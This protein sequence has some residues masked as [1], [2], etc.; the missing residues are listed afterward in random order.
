[1]AKRLG[2]EPAYRN[3]AKMR[4][5][6]RALDIAGR[7]GKSVAHASRECGLA[8][9]RIK[10][11]FRLHRTTPRPEVQQMLD[12]LAKGKAAR[13]AAIAEADAKE[14]RGTLLSKADMEAIVMENT[15]ANDRKGRIAT[16]KDVVRICDAL[17]DSYEVGHGIAYAAKAL[18]IPSDALR[19]WIDSDTDDTRCVAM[20]D[21]IEDGK[22]LRIEALSA[23]VTTSAVGGGK[24]IK[25]RKGQRFEDGRFEETEITI[26]APN[27]PHALATLRAIAPDQYQGDVRRVEV[28]GGIFHTHATDRLEGE[29]PLALTDER[30]ADADVIDAEFELLDGDYDDVPKGGD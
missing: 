15:T 30:G 6:I 29:S 24:R 1:M 26:S 25:K 16:G 13:A 3:K 18:N 27:G 28:S 23:A 17:R 21:A 11:W 19:T 7:R 4:E 9:D 22:A 2:R 14:Q 20:R 10:G 12:A 5:I 8:S